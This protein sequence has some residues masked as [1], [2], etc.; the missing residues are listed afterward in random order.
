M[1]GESELASAQENA[2]A[3]AVGEEA[4]MPEA[5]SLTTPEEKLQ[6]HPAWTAI[7]IHLTWTAALVRPALVPAPAR[8]SLVKPPVMD[9]SMQ[10][11]EEAAPVT[12][13]EPVSAA[14]AAE[15]EPSLDSILP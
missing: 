13:Q 9:D 1:P 2:S 8:L 15:E 14:V 12:A 6:I 10:P 5:D 3:A 11:L 4:G 7:L